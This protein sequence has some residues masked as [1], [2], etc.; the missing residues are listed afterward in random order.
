MEDKFVIELDAET[1]AKFDKVLNDDSVMH[2]ASVAHQ[3]NNINN[4]TDENPDF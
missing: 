4:G 3:A 1:L 2:A